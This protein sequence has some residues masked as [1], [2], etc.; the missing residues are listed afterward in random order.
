[1]Y[2]VEYGTRYQGSGTSPRRAGARRRLR[3]CPQRLRDRLKYLYD[4]VDLSCE[5]WKN[6]FLHQA[7]SRFRVCSR[8][9]PPL[10]ELFPA[11]ASPCSPLPTLPGVAS[12]VLALCPGGECCFRNFARIYL[13]FYP[14]PLVH[15]HCNTRANPDSTT[16]DNK[17]SLIFWL[18]IT[19]P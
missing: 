11:R 17:D 12:T 7:L 6:D 16:E 1:M 10:G 19:N 8:G 4:N 5:A 14:D 3:V 9:G 13:R 2:Q 18:L 15:Y